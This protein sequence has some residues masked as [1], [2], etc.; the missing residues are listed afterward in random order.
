[1][2][3]Q[4]VE[5]TE[6]NVPFLDLRQ[7]NDAYAEEIKAE[8]AAVVDAGWYIRGAAC[9]RF[10]NQFA[11]YCCTTH[12]VGVGNGLDALTLV[13][14]A[15]RELGVVGAGDEVI[16]PANT[17]I[18]SVLAI[19]QAGL[20]PVLV[21]PDER[22]FNLDPQRI[23]AHLTSATRV[24]IPVH[25][26]GQCAEMQSITEIANAHGLKI[27]VDAAQA[28]G[29][30]YRGAR[31]GALGDAAAFS[32]YPGKNLGALGDG[33]AVMTND[34]ELADCVRAFGNYGSRRKHEN[35]Y[36][37]R[38]SRLDEVQAAILSVRLEHLDDDNKRRVAIASRYLR[39]I[40]NPAVRLPTVAPYGTHVWHLFVVRV[41]ERD[42]FRT[43]LES[44]GIETGVHYPIPPH[45]QRAFAEW[46]SLCLPITE[47]IHEQVV[48][49]P[50][51]PVHTDDE[52]S[53]VIEE[54]NA[55]K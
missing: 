24:V 51:S 35:L 14:L 32:F 2:I 7:V 29:A 4:R 30:T 1:M 10:E 55:Y 11:K 18:A 40:S 28:H 48:S 45:K 36:Q 47:R 33:G 21:E 8:M 34:N 9:N 46:N 16:V 31:V 3:K 12:C 25:L 44:R 6:V 27:L 17:F 52:V 39:E 15:W 26:Y 54:V 43:F 5:A 38:N 37:G 19:V 41:A 53:R 49:L 23:E 50:M 22:T 20:T 42:R 13:L